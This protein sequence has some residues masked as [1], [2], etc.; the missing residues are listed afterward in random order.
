[1]THDHVGNRVRDR[2]TEQGL[3]QAELAERVGIARVSILSIEKGRYI[4]TIET[5]LRISNALETP[6]DELFWLREEKE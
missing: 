3:T 1:M 4:P 2:R 5:A 6:I